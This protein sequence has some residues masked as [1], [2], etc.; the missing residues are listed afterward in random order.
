MKKLLLLVVA[1]LGI[2]TAASAQNFGLGD[3]TITATIGLGGG[4]GTPIAVSYEKAVVDLGSDWL[5]GVGAFAGFSSYSES[6][7]SYKY[8]YSNIF[9]AG[10]GNFHYC[11]FS[12]W[13]LYTGLRL[14]YNIVS[15]SWNDSSYTGDS[16]LSTSS[17]IYTTHIGA[18]YALNNTWSINAE[19]GYGLA[20]L[21][22]GVTYKL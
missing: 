21:S 11:G 18:N 6:Y 20:S 7:S 22:L 10:E 14:G 4:Y 12:K 17:L 1:V 9:L 15:G 5:I 16:S 3:Q 13:D 2:S 8:T 19:L